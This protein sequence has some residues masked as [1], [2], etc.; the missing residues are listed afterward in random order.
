[1]SESQ[2]G[3]RNLQKRIK[4]CECTRYQ[5]WITA[6]KMLI[7]KGDNRIL[8]YYDLEYR[9]DGGMNTGCQFW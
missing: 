3:G 1:M 4:I 8:V 5:F 7:L 2:T 6:I 9:D